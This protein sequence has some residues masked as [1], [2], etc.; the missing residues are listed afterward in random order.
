MWKI[1]NQKIII[2]I[3]ELLDLSPL[4]SKRGHKLEV[5]VPR[6]RLEVRKRFSSCIGFSHWNN[7]PPDT[8]SS[9]SLEQLKSRLRLILEKIFLKF[10]ERFM[11]CMY[12]VL[13]SV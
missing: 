11:L 7:L 5:F 13:Q 4:N 12:L 9:S 3:N 1:F 6:S 10:F 8:V 2:K